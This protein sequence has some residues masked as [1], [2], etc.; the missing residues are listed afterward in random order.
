MP[1]RTFP[2]D[3]LTRA[4]ASGNV[5]AFS[6]LVRQYRAGVLRTAFGILG[7]AQEAD[8]VAQEV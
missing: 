4:A 1:E 8:D 6:E 5:G 7:S 3:S 2:E